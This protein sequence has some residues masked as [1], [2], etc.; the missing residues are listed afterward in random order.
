MARELFDLGIYS[1]IDEASAIGSGWL[2][3]FYLAGTT[4]ETDTYTLPSGGVANS[5]PVEA[6]SNGRFPQ[7]WREPGSYKFVLYDA[8]AVPIH[9]VDN[10][11]VAA[12]PP[13]ITAALNNFLAGSSPLPIANGGTSQATA[14]NAIAGLGGLPTAGGTMTGAITRSTKGVFL[15]FET[16]GMV[17]GNVFLTA[18]GDPDPSTLAGQ[19]WLK[20]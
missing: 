8:D 3:G 1:V 4:T 15:F 6:D 10:D 18:A 9:T 5:N 19:V 17:N 20:Y 12:T 13:T 2:L 11:L 7:I 14:A 16:V